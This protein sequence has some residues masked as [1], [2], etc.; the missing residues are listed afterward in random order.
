MLTRARSL[1]GRSAPRLIAVVLTGAL[2]W[3]ARAAAH[4]DPSSQIAALT[5]QIAG[6]PGNAV[7]Y[8]RRAELHR[9][10]RELSAALSDYDRARRLDPGLVVADLGAGRALREAGRPED[11][12]EFLERYVRARPN[13]A[14]ARL[15]LAR[16]LVLLGSTNAA[17]AEYGRAIA[18]TSKPRPD[19]YFER[20][21][22][23]R[24][25]GRLPA[26]I[27]ALDEGI[28]RLG[29]I[30]SLEELAV[31]LELARRNF[32][33]ALVRLERIYPAGGR[34]ETRLARR[35]DILASAGRPIEARQAFVEAQRSIEAL[36]AR[37]RQTRAIQKL[38]GRVRSS[39]ESLRVAGQKEK[40]DAKS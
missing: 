31:E 2:L 13:D 1:H 17:D 10:D 7:L 6:E 14:E 33:G 25:A 3:S 9:L 29:P 11:A 18:L 4:D 39:L 15:E 26:A 22:L 8:L 23:L 5:R 21:R 34:Q 27:R 40:T 38:E 24:E 28:V 16:A 12:K 19:V 37:L 20:A 35:G 36:P 30:A 32:D